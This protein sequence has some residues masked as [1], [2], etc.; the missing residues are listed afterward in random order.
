M[1]IN[2]RVSGAEL[3]HHRGQVIFSYLY[4]L[5]FARLSRGV[6]RTSLL[7]PFRH[8]QYAFAYMLALSARAETWSYSI[9][10]YKQFCALLLDTDIKPQLQQ[11]IGSAGRWCSTGCRVLLRL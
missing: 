6:L 8:Y 10:C 4:Q 9:S 3:G 7:S 1:D 2:I 5:I 11:C